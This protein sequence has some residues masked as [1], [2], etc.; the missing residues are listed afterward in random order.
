MFTGLI[1]ALGVVS[2]SVRVGAGYRLRIDSA[3]AGDRLD[4]GESISVDGVCLTVVRFSSEWFEADGSDETLRRTT[5]GD[6]T[7]GRE[8]NLERALRLSDRLGGHLVT[9]HV[10]SVGTLSRIKQIGEGAELGF[11]ISP[12]LEPFLVEKG[13]VA[14][15]GVSLTVNSCQSGSFS[16]T[17]VPHTLA[18]TTLGQK[19]VGDRVNLEGDLIGKYV[20]RTLHRLKGDDQRRGMDVDFLKRHGFV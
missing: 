5:L 2:K 13:S 16:V 6:Y 17:L 4:L 18:S 15:D 10:D 9:G 8:V 7:S 11:A 20:V 14:V 3:I 19:R 12:D 1:Q